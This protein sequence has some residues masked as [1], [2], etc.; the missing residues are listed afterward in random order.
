[1]KLDFLLQKVFTWTIILGHSMFHG[2]EFGFSPDISGG[3]VA[4]VID[5]D[6]LQFDKASKKDRII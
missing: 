3:K 1:M 6:G 5:E 4:G 2:K